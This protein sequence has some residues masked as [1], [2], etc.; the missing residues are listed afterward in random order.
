MLVLVIVVGCTQDESIQNST[1]GTKYVMN[2]MGDSTGE[3]N[4]EILPMV[5]A[6]AAT[7]PLRLADFKFPYRYGEAWKITCGYGC[8]KHVNTSYP[9]AGLYSV[10]L[11]RVNKQTSGSCVL[12]PARGVVVFAGKMTGYG[13]CVVM[14]HDYGHTGHGYKSIVAHLQ[15]DPTQFVRVGD[16]LLAG[17][18]LG[19]AGASGT[20]IPH[21]HFSVWR[22]NTTVPIND[23]SGYRDLYSGGVYYSQNW[24]VQPPRGY[25][26]CY[27][28]D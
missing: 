2:P 9:Y 13:W 3:K 11:V 20:S 14:D 7:W 1:E 18:I 27:Q 8:Y 19:Y 6:G 28:N 12:A 15:S 24:S 10:D 4:N 26:V 22:H 17:T 21:I 5:A 25:C 23:I 16:D